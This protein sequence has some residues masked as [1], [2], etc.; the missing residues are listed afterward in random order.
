MKDIFLTEESKKEIEDRINR[1]ESINMYSSSINQITQ[2]EL[3][4]A[5]YK[6]IL[7]SAII[8]PVEDS[9]EDVDF[10][11]DYSQPQLRNFYLNGVII[12]S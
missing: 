9:W 12:K 10:I 2:N 3:I 4:N 6:E 7:E 1:L 11:Y 5:V 8:L